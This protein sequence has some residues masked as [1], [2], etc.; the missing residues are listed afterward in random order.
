MT[1]DQDLFQDRHI[2]PSPDDQAAMLATLGYDS[3]DAFIDAVVPEDIRLRPPAG[4]PPRDKQTGS[5]GK[6]AQARREESV[7]PPLPRQGLSR[8]LPPRRDPAERARE[9]RLVHGLHAV[10]A[11]DRAGAARSAAQLSDD[12]L[13]PDRPRDRECVVAR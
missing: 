5:S 13:G 6:P 12:G 3:L 2:G 1:I 10:S 9:S 8:L 7:F 11:G 4:N